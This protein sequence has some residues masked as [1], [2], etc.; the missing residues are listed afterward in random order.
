MKT[1]KVPPPEKVCK[2]CGRS[3]SYRK[4][5]QNCWDTVLY[6]SDR[7][8]GQKSNENFETAILDLLKKRDAHKT[9]CPS[10][11]LPN[12]Q[13]QDKEQM[14]RVRQSARKLAHQS[15]IEITQNSKVVSP[16]VFR[17]PHSASPQIKRHYPLF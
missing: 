12:E 3:F 1:K 8:R 7:C 4:K 16:D 5:W 2:T 9:I 11:V 14:E 6:C 15:L 17:G 13:K 10:E